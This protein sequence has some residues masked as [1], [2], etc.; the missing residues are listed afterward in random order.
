MAK[1]LT[2]TC[3]LPSGIVLRTFEMRDVEG[4][5]RAVSTGDG[6]ALHCGE[7]PDVD[8]EMFDRWMDANKDSDIVKSGLLFVAPK[9]PEEGLKPLDPPKAAEPA[10]VDPPAPA[11]AD[12][13]EKPA[14]PQGT[15]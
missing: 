8:A 2:V 6:L 1:T 10:K 3:G 7:N 14:K 11:A 5:P 13:P 12:K 15:A 4:A 9:M